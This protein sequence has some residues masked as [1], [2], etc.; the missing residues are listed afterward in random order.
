MNS[1][2]RKARIT[3]SEF[4]YKLLYLLSEKKI[5]LPRS[6]NQIYEN[7]R[8]FFVIEDKDSGCLSGCAA[9]HVF[10]K[11]IAEVRSLA[12]SENMQG[13]GFGRILVEACLK[14]AE[15]LG[16]SRVFALTYQVPFFE[17]MGFKR[18]D[19]E[20]LP[21]KIWSDCL[22]CVKFPDCDEVSLLWTSE[23]AHV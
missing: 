19:K 18:V 3:D 23:K 8:D 5:I 11:D 10:W 16:I 17:K 13:K 7:I 14:E 2:V 6:Y 4:I 1:H 22:N 20:E 21:H 9:L 15:G 12:V